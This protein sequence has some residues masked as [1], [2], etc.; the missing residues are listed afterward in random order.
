MSKMGEELE[1]RVEANKYEVYAALGALLK[2][3]EALYSDD[4]SE[5][6]NES[7]PAIVKA[8]QA[9]SKIEDWSSY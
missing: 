7:D 2:W 9:I 4:T 6:A 1:K 3:A 8:K 5:W